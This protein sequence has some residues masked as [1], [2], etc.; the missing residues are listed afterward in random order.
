MRKVKESTVGKT[1]EDELPKE[2][3]EK[4]A[5]LGIKVSSLQEAANMKIDKTVDHQKAVEILGIKEEA[6]K[7][8]EITEK[9][10]VVKEKR[11]DSIIDPIEEEVIKEMNK[12]Y[13]IVH[14]SSTH[15][16]IEKGAAGFILDSRSSLIHLHENDF[17]TNSEGKKINKAKFWLKHPLR[18]TYFDIV[19][20]VDKPPTFEN[21]KK[22]EVYNIFKGFA[23]DP[24][25]GDASLYWAHVKNVVCG[26]DEALYLSVR[27]RMASIVQNPSLLGYSIVLRGKQGTGK[28][29]CI[30]HFCKLFGNHALTFT[31]LERLTGRFN[32]HLQYALV[33]F[34]NEAIWG[35]NKKEIGALKAL[36][37]D[38][39]IFIEGKGKDGYQI[40]NARH[41]LVASNE[42]WVVPRDMDDRRFLVLDVSSKHKE[43]HKY[44][45][46]LEK[47]MNE[48]GYEALL[49]DLQNE[50]LT[51]FDP[52]MMPISDAGFDMK[53]KS[54]PTSVQYLYSALNEGCWHIA[55]SEQHWEFEIKK[56]CIKLYE[57]YKDWC[58][59]QKMPIQSI[60]EFGKTIKNF[61]PKSL[62][63]KLRYEN[64]RINTYIFPSIKECRKDFQDISKQTSK[65]WSDNQ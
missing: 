12:Q 60:E 36:I 57:N 15:I 41:L 47:Q 43:D 50:D 10:K 44:F 19:F 25:K 59:S 65:I 42:E 16:L 48:G 63:S 34:A 26:G 5:K 13:A 6:K 4:I 30:E 18:R 1:K 22:Q 58:E 7:I 8:L 21:E 35:G 31:S 24:K 14:T 33:L 49:Y 27:K 3:H 54:A 38:P 46:A 11:N 56:P 17:F 55:G 53:I 64:S 28:N 20:E 61:I 62:K 2:M 37:S 23:F 39:T 45:A 32:S 29:Q 9:A 52:R 51:N 40:H